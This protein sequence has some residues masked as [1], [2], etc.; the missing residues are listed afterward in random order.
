MCRKTLPKS[1]RH[2]LRLSLACLGALDDDGDD[3]GGK[4]DG[5][6][7]PPVVQV[8]IAGASEGDADGQ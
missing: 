4:N 1:Q 2:D 3:D 5:D 7:D 8:V 6:H